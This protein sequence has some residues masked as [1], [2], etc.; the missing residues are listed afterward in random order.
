MELSPA[1]CAFFNFRGKSKKA[2][3]TRKRVSRA[4]EALVFERPSSVLCFPR[5]LQSPLMELSPARRALFKH[6]PKMQ[7]W[8]N[9]E[10]GTHEAPEATLGPPEASQA[11]HATPP[12]PAPAGLRLENQ[13]FLSKTQ[14][15][16][17]SIQPPSASGSK[18]FLFQLIQPHTYTR[19]HKHA[20]VHT[21]I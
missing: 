2:A 17:V 3:Q 19:A 9:I 5:I 15:K 12:S 11:F 18:L 6:L 14:F 1:P 4:R 10:N 21:P 7:Q 20:H 8:P 16:I 13:P